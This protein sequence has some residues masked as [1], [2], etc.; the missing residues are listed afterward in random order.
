MGR[1]RP[2]E[3]GLA[4]LRLPGGVAVNVPEGSINYNLA[5]YLADTSAGAPRTFVFDHLNFESG[6]TRLAPESGKTVS[7]MA[8]ILKAYPTAEVRL[9]GYT[10]STGDP[11]ANK[12]LSLD[13]ANAIKQQLVASGVDGNRISTAG[14]GQ[15]RPVASND[16]EEGRA[17]NRRTELVVLHK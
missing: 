6:T 8:A 16:A 4:N 15:D 17:R 1:S 7:D 5:K 13:R 11:A 14:M 3:Q 12:Q 10:D 2:I 9:D